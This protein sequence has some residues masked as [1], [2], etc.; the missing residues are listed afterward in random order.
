METS[1]RQR[2]AQLT[3]ERILT[4]AVREFSRVGFAASTVKSI[5]DAAEVSPNLITRYF[6]GKD[7]LF[8]AA[9]QVHLGVDQMFDGPRESLGMRM[10]DT[11]VQRWDTLR[12]DDPLLVLLRSAGERSSAAAM[13]TDF[14]DR[15]S[16]E[17]L[18]RQLEEYGMPPAD[19][20]SKARSVDVF[21]LG[22]TTRLRMLRDDLG[23]LD[24][25]RT[26]IGGTI[27]AIVDAK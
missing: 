20:A 9:A 19:A 5:A 14:L 26:W 2:N 11:I 13:L 21:L 27:Q 1:P 7:G 12:G 24:A 4:A 8:V 6:G 15:E 10:A 25:A 17:P 22:V 16:L 3:R 18:R 23:D